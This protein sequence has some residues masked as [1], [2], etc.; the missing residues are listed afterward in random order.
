MKKIIVIIVVL[1][2]SLCLFGQEAWPYVSS[3][4]NAY[5][6]GCCLVL[7]AQ[8]VIVNNRKTYLDVDLVL[9]TFIYSANDTYTKKGDVKELFEILLYY[10]ND[11]DSFNLITDSR[12]DVEISNIFWESSDLYPLTVFPS[13]AVVDK[14]EETFTITTYIS[15]QKVL[16]YFSSYKP[17]KIRLVGESSSTVIEINFDYDSEI[18]RTR[19]PICIDGYNSDRKEQIGKMK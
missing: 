19:L 3:Y 12:F 5:G 17:F 14:Q 6:H 8:Q 13:T 2:F 4:D 18:G 15:I 16:D 1:C 7:P 11:Y 9:I 10:S